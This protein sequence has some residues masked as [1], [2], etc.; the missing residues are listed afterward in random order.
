VNI[1][2]QLAKAEAYPTSNVDE[3]KININEAIMLFFLI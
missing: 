2:K 3:K 1:F